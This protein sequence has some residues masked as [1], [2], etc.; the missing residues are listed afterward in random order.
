MPMTQLVAQLGG[1][2]VLIL[3]LGVTSSESGSDSG[4]CG[5]SGPAA[6]GSSLLTLPKDSKQVPFQTSSHAGCTKMI[7]TCA[8]HGAVQDWYDANWTAWKLGFSVCCLNSY[9]ESF[10]VQLDAELFKFDSSVEG[11]RGGDLVK[12][13]PEPALSDFCSQGNDLLHTHM[14]HG[15]FETDANGTALL[16]TLRSTG[17]LI[18]SVLSKFSLELLLKSSTKTRAAA[19]LRKISVCQESKE[20]W[21]QVTNVQHVLLQVVQSDK[22]ACWRQDMSE[23]NPGT[24]IKKGDALRNWLAVGGGNSTACGRQLDECIDRPRHMASCQLYETQRMVDCQDEV[25]KHICEQIAGPDD[26]FVEC[27]VADYDKAAGYDVKLV[28]SS[29]ALLTFGWMCNQAS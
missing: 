6:R 14:D 23:C 12:G 29:I 22:R 4:N 26:T 10:C 16:Q 18:K 5:V 1:A 9:P 24:K 7:K 3:F 25:L 15:T 13:S 2:L 8:G 19:V 11:L 21:E 27:Q 17:A 28:V 20:C